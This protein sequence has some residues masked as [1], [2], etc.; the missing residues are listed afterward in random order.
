M[1]QYKKSDGCDAQT[2]QST[3]SASVSRLHPCRLA[4]PRKQKVSRQKLSR[5]QEALQCPTLQ[6]FSKRTHEATKQSRACIFS[7][8]ARLFVYLAEVACMCWGFKW[9]SLDISCNKSAILSELYRSRYARLCRL[10]IANRLNTELVGGYFFNSR[11]RNNIS[12]D[13]TSCRLMWQN[14]RPPSCEHHMSAAQ[15]IHEWVSNE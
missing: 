5:T 6:L 3:I 1:F 10:L 13:A 7:H 2:T 12:R 11:T 8:G 15:G 9:R 14:E 4:K